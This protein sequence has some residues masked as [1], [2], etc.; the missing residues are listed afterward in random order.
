MLFC[1]KIIS[2]K[3]FLTIERALNTIF[4]NKKINNLIQIGANDGKSNDPIN[5]FI[6]E[7]KKN[8]KGY[9]FEPDP[10]YYKLLTN[11]YKKNKNLKIFNL[12]IHN[13]L[14]TNKLYKVKEPIKNIDLLSMPWELYPPDISIVK[15][16]N[17]VN[18]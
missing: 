14:K 15:N 6:K 5:F 2:H 17:R 16:E 13:S 18:I 9:L 4:E 3:S 8:V 7:N 11:N 1:R 12:A 10:E